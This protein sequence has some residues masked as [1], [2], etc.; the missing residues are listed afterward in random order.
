MTVEEMKQIIQK[1]NLATDRFAIM[2]S[3]EF[4]FH[5]IEHRLGVGNQIILK[6]ASEDNYEIILYN[7]WGYV[8]MHEQN[9]SESEACEKA[10]F[11]LR[12]LKNFD[13]Q[14]YSWKP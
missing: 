9:L 10:V 11:S 7:S 4:D 5:N 14:N 8:V 6:I 2:S 12:G 1:E 3:E 13:S